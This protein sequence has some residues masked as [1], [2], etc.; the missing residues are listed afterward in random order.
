MTNFKPV[1]HPYTASK[2]LRVNSYLVET[3]NGVVVIDGTLALSTSREIRQIIDDQIKKPLLAVL[4][5]HGHPDHYI[6]VGEIVRGRDVPIF[7]T[8]GAIDF[9]HEEDRVKFDTLIRR[10]FGED[11]PAQRVFP[12]QIVT[13][14]QVLVLDGVEF[15]IE[16][17]GPC[18]SGSDSMWVMTIDGVPH[19]FLGD[20]IYNHS[21]CYFRDGHA[22]NWLQAL[23]RLLDKFHYTAL[24]YPGHGDV[25]GTEMV[26]WQ[27]AYIEAFLDTLHAMLAGRDAL[28]EVEKE[29]LF[30]R[31]KSFL[32]SD[33]NLDLL[34]YE[35]DETIHL[36]ANQRK[37]A[38]VR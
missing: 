10:N 27:R 11:A 9:A 16:D 25:C 24:L 12:N 26:Y 20:I 33:E 13:D 35:P 36:L 17:M 32:P 23:D 31:M 14:N 7:A 18:E 8:Q 34:T 37:G 15:R 22:L 21:H 1:I 28:D 2:Y 19:V 30:S 38:P 5:T 29:R 4:L 6:G 3:E